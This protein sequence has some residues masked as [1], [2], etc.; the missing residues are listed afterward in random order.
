MKKLKVFTDGACLNNG[1][2]NATAGIGIYFPNGELKEISKKFTKEPITNQRAELGAILTAVQLIDLYGLYQMY[3]KVVIFTD[4]MY[5]INCLTEW[6]NKWIQNGWK[7]SKKNI[8]E[9]QDLIKKIHKYIQKYNIKFRHVKAHT[10]KTN[11]DSYYNA[12]VDILASN[13]AKN[14]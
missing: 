5:S 12:I 1:K 7:N 4:S 13:A 11:S 2:K 14:K 10:K 3:D 8:V 9:N 6:I